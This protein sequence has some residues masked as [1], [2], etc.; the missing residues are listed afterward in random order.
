MASRTL[1]DI[2]YTQA[3]P[4]FGQCAQCHQ[5]FRTP[6][7]AMADREKATRDFYAAFILHEC[8]LAEHKV[9]PAK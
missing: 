9:G 2:I 4:T 3:V 8:R 7:D 5:P 6:S 1:K